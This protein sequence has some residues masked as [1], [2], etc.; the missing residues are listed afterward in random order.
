MKT[1]HSDPL[2]GGHEKGFLTMSHFK[3]HHL[4]IYV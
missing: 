3:N 2:V 4:H 1:N